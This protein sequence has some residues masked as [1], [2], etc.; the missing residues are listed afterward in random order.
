MK[1]QCLHCTLEVENDVDDFCCLGCKTAYKIINNLGFSS[2]Y[3]L[4]QINEKERKIRPREDE[5]VDISQFVKIENEKKSVTLMVQGLHCAA[6]VWLIENI[7]KKQKAVSLA[8]VNLSQ[9]MLK[10]MWQGEVDYGNQLAHLISQIGYKLLPF[11]AEILQKAEKKYDDTIL[12]AMAVAGFGAGNIM[13]LSIS[14]WFSD[15]LDM[16]PRTHNLLQFFSCLIAIPVLLY[17]SRPFF[18]SA[19]K[20]IKAGYPNMDLPISL[21]IVL[22]SC[23]SILQMMKNANHIYFDSVV[24]LIFFLLIGRYLDLKAR[25]KAFEIASEFTLLS[26]SFGRVLIDDKIVTLPIKKIE[27]DMIL[28]VAAGEKIAADGFV[29]EGESEVDNSMINGESLPQKIMKNCAVFAGTINITEP[30]KI[31]V[32]KAQNE[33]LMAQILE[34]VQIAQDKKNSYVRLA[35]SLSKFYTPAIHILAILTFA[36]WFKNGFEI[37]LMN[38]TAVLIITCPCALALAVPIVQTIAISRFIKRGILIKSGEALEKIS[39]IDIIIF[40]KTGSLTLGKPRLKAIKFLDGRELN[41]AQKNYYLQIAASLSAQSRHIISRAISNAY[42]GNIIALD[43]KEERGFGLSASFEEKELRLGKKD[44]CLIKN[45][46][47]AEILENNLLNC[48]LKIGDEELILL[49]EDQLKEDAFEVISTL[50]KQNKKVILLSGDLENPVKK[51]AS[52]LKI[53]EFYF[54]KTPLQ[55]AEFLQNLKAQNKK[56]IMVGDGINDAPSLALADVSISFSNA[57]DIAQNIADIV[58]CNDKLQPILQLKKDSQ[59]SLRLMKQ[60]LIIAL[61]Y[62]IFALPFAFLG[63]VTP[64]FAALAMSSSSLLVLFNSLRMRK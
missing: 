58:I 27:K 19:Y 21:A 53:D 7:L 13:L 5:E 51:I 24:M 11:D 61:I 44:F 45:D 32:S 12:R 20:S 26:A 63:F 18:S 49:F 15:S 39:Q 4:R 47:N 60:N 40:D 52:D 55:K 6:C 17:S 30:L 35:D 46:F 1:K 41:E 59:K 29:I 37:A 3:N 48:F 54:E 25:K 8:R 34:F 42:A 14:L 2:Y 43:A 22:A 33:S 28:L 31:R 62:N 64:L 16:G 38:A 10:I 36:F 50:K 57:S 56:F 23:V 9:K